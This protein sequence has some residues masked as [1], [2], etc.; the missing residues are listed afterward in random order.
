M[1]IV[2]GRVIGGRVE[3]EDYELPEGADVSVVIPARQDEEYIPT[4]EEAAEI[5]AGFDE[6][7]RGESVPLEEVMREVRALRMEEERRRR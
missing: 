6:L 3:V 7:D 5:E 4:D 1:T 2:P